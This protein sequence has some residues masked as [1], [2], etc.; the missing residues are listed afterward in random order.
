MTKY[1]L[2]QRFEIWNDKTGESINISAD[3]DGLDLIEIRWADPDSVTG[4]I[5]LTQE[6]ATLLVQALLGAMQAQALKAETENN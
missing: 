1:S 6:Q 4:A 2:E 3:Y 5:T